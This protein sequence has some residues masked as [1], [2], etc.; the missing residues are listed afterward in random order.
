MSKDLEGPTIAVI[1]KADSGK[2]TFIRAVC[3]AASGTHGECTDDE[4]TSD[5]VE[6]R[7]PLSGGLF[8][9]F[10]DTPGFDGN[11]ANSEDATTE[12]ILNELEKYI[13][14]NSLGPRAMFKSLG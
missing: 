12:G 4:P 1:G 6:Y 8:M 3:D 9:T 10:L 5:I 2:T 11:L 7:V 14:E 13:A